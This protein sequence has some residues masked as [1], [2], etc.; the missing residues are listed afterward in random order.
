MMEKYVACLM[1]TDWFERD[2]RNIRFSEEALEDQRTQINE[3]AHIPFGFDHNPI[4]MPIGRTDSAWLERANGTTSLMATCFVRLDASFQSHSKSGTKIADLQLGNSS[5]GFVGNR[6]DATDDRV[7]ISVDRSDF[8]HAESWNAFVEE[9]TGDDRTVRVREYARNSLDPDGL[10]LITLGAWAVLR[11]EKFARHVIDETL[12]KVGD[13]VSDRLSA[14][15]L[16]AMSVFEQT[17]PKTLE[18]YHVVMIFP[19]QP[20]LVLVRERHVGELGDMVDE[21]KSG[22]IGDVLATYGDLFSESQ[23]IT[24]IRELNGEWSFQHTKTADGN[25]IGDWECYQ[26]SVGR[27]KQIR[28]LGGG[29]PV[30]P[31][32]RPSE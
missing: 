32:G 31:A 9:M 16:N 3:E 26:A 23:E 4:L 7:V 10:I 19:G 8:E 14:L 2:N 13:E 12:R 21:V 17:A 29:V 20:Q 27:W 6:Q 28:K 11:L 24:L 18:K 22:E 5:R 15:I 25:I 30:S 1:T